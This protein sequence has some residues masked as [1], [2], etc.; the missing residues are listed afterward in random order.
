MTKSSRLKVLTWGV[1]GTLILGSYVGGET[2]GLASG[3]RT[4][5]NPIPPDQLRQSSPGSWHYVYWYHGTR[6]K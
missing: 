3:G 5:K 1:V 6:G 4:Q 2:L